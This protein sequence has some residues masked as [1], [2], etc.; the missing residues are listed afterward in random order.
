M[1]ILSV[2][3]TRLQFIEMAVLAK[4]FNE[5]NLHHTM[6]VEHRLLHTGQ[7]GDPLLP[8]VFFEELDLPDPEVLLGMHP[9]PPGMETAAMLASLEVALLQGRPDAVVI[10]GDS[11]GHNTLHAGAGRD[12]LFAGIGI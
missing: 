3:G 2:G 10:Y 9:G 12:T 8:G 7:H 5:Y 1:K 11:T 4:A 6:Q